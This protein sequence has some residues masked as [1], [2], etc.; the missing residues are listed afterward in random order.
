M[1]HIVSY[2]V[3]IMMEYRLSIMECLT[4]CH[5][6]LGHGAG[7]QPGTDDGV[8]TSAG[9]QQIQGRNCDIQ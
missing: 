8:L 9:R 4:C 7:E 1:N 2:C 3:E 5:Q 6:V